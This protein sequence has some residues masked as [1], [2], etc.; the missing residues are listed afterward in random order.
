MN[1]HISTHNKF[2]IS[3]RSFHGSCSLTL[4][5]IISADLGTPPE[6]V[7]LKLECVQNF[8]FFSQVSLDL[9]DTAVANNPSSC[10]GVGEPKRIQGRILETD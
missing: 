3:V 10:G 1:R 5:L 4:S 8:F 9:D 2:L 7:V 6:H